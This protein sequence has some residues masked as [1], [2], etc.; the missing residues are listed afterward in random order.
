MKRLFYG[1]LILLAIFA[2]FKGCENKH[3]K[4]KQ[5]PKEETERKVKEFLEDFYRREAAILSLK[6]KVDEEK[7]FNILVAENDIMYTKSDKE[8]WDF[9]NN[10]SKNTRQRIESYSAEYNIPTDIIASILID[11]DLMRHNSSN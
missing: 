7:V 6:Y 2:L 4:T 3:S 1:F 5:M 9:L 8:S 11:Y 10:Y